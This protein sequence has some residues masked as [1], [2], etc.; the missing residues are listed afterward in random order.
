MVPFKGKH[1][2]KMYMPKK[3]VKWGY[4]L[5][6]RAGI[7]GYVY[8]FEV[9]GELGAKGSPPNFNNNN[10]EYGESEF[11]VLRLTNNLEPAKHHVFFDNLFASPNLLSYL[12]TKQI[13]IKSNFNQVHTKTRQLV[14]IS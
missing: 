10:D 11:V 1:A 2:A 8:D 12:K 13:C 6:S 4:K 5:W 9:C 14:T 3:P 7:S